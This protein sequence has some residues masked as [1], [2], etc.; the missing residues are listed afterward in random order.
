MVTVK[1]VIPGSIAGKKGIKEEDIL[2]SING[3]KINDLLDYRFYMTERR[4]ELVLRRGEDEYA[5]K[6]LKGEYDDIGLEFETFLMDKK[7]SCHN[8]CIFCFIDQNP[9]GMREGIYF[10]DDDTRLSFLHGNYVTLTNIKKEEIERILKMHISPINISVHTTNPQLRCRMLGNKNAGN[11]LDIIK[12]LAKGKITVN[13]QIVLCRGVNDK[14]ELNKTLHDLAEGFPFV[15]S[16]AVVPAGLTKHREGLYP[17]KDFDR[18]ESRAVIGQVEQISDAFLGKYGSRF[19]FLADEFYVR[20]ELPP[21][22]EEYYGDYPQLDNGVGL[23][24]SMKNDVMREMEFLKQERDVGIKKKISL[25]T[26]EAAYGY[27]KGLVEEIKK[28]WYNIDCKVYKVEN[29]FYGKTVTVSGLLTGSD[30]YSA[31]RGKDLGDALYISASSLRHEGDKFLDDMT[32]SE[33]Q[34]KLHVKIV[35]TE[36]GE[37]FLL[38]ITE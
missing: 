24:T 9:P 30:Y 37:D 16:V 21:H 29:R 2:L 8:R 10:K 26:G 6:L 23:M 19:V 27:I 33:L 18:E 15:S 11:I 12:T 17:L 25:A 13:C 36:A 14:E 3:H 35:P 34:E 38:K 20:A 32:L 7:R 4:L 5:V 22:G 1:K 31:L 28:I